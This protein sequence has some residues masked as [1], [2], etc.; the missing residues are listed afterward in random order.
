M[1]EEQALQKLAALCSQSEHCTS[2]MKEKM[3]RWGIDEDAQQRVVEYLVANRYVDDRRYARSF[4]N[5]KLKYNKW[6]PRKIEQSLWMKHIDESILREALDDVD[7]EEYISVLRPLLTSKRKTTKAET[8]YE[9]NQKLLRFAI[10]RGFTFEQ[11]KEVIDD[12][13]E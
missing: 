9:M 12:V 10:G 1:T 8:D 6:G 5:D 13:D 3:T 2:E 4:V 7:N 11:V